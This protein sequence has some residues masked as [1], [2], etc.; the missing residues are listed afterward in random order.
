MLECTV[1]EDLT[2]IDVSLYAH[3]MIKGIDYYVG[4]TKMGTYH[5][6]TY[7][8]YVSGEGEG[9][10]VGENKEALTDIVEKFYTY[11]KSAAAYKAEVT[12]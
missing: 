7:Y 4:E 2:Y 5:I 10:Y 12:K 3:R 8:D 1:S 9:C 6:N 11:C